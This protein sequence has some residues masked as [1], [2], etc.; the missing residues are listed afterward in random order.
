LI[1]AGFAAIGTTSLGVAAANGLPDA[2]GL[3]RA[4]TLALAH[5]LGRLDCLFTVDIEA[6]FSEDPDEVAAL[7]VELAVAGAVGVN[8]EDG[9]PDGTLAPVAEQQRLISAIATAAPQLYLNARTDT[10]WLRGES[11]LTDTIARASAYLDAGAD[12]IFVPGLAAASDVATVVASVGAPVNVLY[13]PSRHTVR[14]LAD[15]GVRRVSYGSL[16]FRAALHAA[17][18]TAQAVAAGQSTA[19]DIPGY[20]EVQALLR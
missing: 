11:S 13:L 12:G 6:G 4:E 15:L 20:A 1:G 7:A 16:L 5:R 9:R 14:A 18:Q 2:E 3:A 19:D 17:V 8:L 10:H